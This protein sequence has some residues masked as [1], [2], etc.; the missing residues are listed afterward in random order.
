MLAITL[1]FLAKQLK[2]SVTKQLFM[3]GVS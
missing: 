1:P 2:I 3:F